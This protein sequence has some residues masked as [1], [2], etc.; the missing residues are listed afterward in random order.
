MT[1]YYCEPLKKEP[2]GDNNIQFHRFY[3]II[4]DRYYWQAEWLWD[5]SLM[6][7]VIHSFTA[8]FL[9]DAVIGDCKTMTELDNLE[10]R[11]KFGSFA[12][13]LERAVN[14]FKSY[15]MWVSPDPQQN[16]IPWQYSSD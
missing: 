2:P 11:D 7:A 12:Y 6:N 9:N 10:M 8:G 1:R 4:D 13:Y 5:T 14:G 15:T 16:D 3:A